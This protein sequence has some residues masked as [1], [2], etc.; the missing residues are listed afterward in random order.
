[1]ASPALSLANTG[2]VNKNGPSQPPSATLSVGAP[3]GIGA[4]VTMVRPVPVAT[5]MAVVS[6]SGVQVVNMSSPHVSAPTVM[7]GAQP[8]KIMGPRLQTATALR[9]QPAI[10]PRPNV[11]QMGGQVKS[12]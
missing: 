9:I 8:Q 6:S 2:N 11:I 7:A 1:M 12:I 5:G 4:Q 10:A 3:H